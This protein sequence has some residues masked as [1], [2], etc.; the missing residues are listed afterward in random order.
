MRGAFHRS[1]LE[2]TGALRSGKQRDYFP[3][4][5]QRNNAGSPDKAASRSSGTRVYACGRNHGNKSR[6]AGNRRK[7]QR[8]ADGSGEGR[9]SGGSVLPF[10]RNSH[11]YPPLRERKEDIPLLADF[12]IAKF[13]A[14]RSPKESMPTL[15]KLFENYRWPGNVRELEN[16]IERLVILSPGEVI[17]LDQVPNSMKN[18][19]ARAPTLLPV[20]IPAEGLD[21]EVASGKRRE[22]CFS[23][24]R[25]RRPAESKPRLQ[26][27]SA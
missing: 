17:T 13:S 8:F 15:M 18:V 23:R 2:Q 7:Q 10:K 27:F 12:F 19:P 24:K 9:V 6:C 14:G 26:N 5:N 20:D 1:H 3:G 4:R 21:L 22:A 16:T 11:P 25:W